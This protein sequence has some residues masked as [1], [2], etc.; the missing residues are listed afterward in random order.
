MS[1]QTG[2]P[3]NDGLV[4]CPMRESLVRVIGRTGCRACIRFGAY[5]GEYVYCDLAQ[6]E[7]SCNSTL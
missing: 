4:F 6:E 2:I 1:E 5:D 7:E 3:I